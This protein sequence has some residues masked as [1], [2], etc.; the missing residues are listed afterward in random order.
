M[1]RAQL[2]RACVVQTNAAIL[3]NDSKGRPSV[4]VRFKAG[5]TY[6]LPEWWFTPLRAQ[7]ALTPT[8]GTTPSPWSDPEPDT[9]NHDPEE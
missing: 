4:R 7:G 2:T 3:L 6:N 1:R 5:H 8:G 9:I